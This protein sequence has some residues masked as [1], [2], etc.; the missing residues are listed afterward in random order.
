MPTTGQLDRRRS[1]LQSP[2]YQHEQ[3][4]R[5]PRSQHPGRI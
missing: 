3:P 1:Q 4:L 2:P 5:P